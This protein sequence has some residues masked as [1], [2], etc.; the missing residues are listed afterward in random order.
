M[1]FNSLFFSMNRRSAVETN[2]SQY[3]K[4][5]ADSARASHGS[6]SY[7]NYASIGE[8]ELWEGTTLVSENSTSHVTIPNTTGLTGLT[9]PLAGMERKITV[10]S[11]VELYG[12]PNQYNTGFGSFHQLSS[13]VDNSDSNFSGSYRGFWK[14]DVYPDAF[15][16]VFQFSSLKNIDKVVMVNLN[17]S[18][19][20]YSRITH[21]QY[22]N[23]TEYVDANFTEN[24]TF[25][26]AARN[27]YIIT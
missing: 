15:E 22:W 25:A 18:Q 4:I 19:Q 6:L 21:I 14:G 27:D 2:T 1:V 3:W 13:I 26:S 23:G 8:I 7:S 10:S 20:Y 5:K 11:D 17:D 16:F 24:Y 12:V 9:G